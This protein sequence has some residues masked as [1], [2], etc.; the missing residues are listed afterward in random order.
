MIVA[1]ARNKDELELIRKLQMSSLMIVP[2]ILKKKAIGA[3][4]FV[5]AESGRH[6]TKNDLIMAE[7]IASRAA[8]AIENSKL[9]NDAKST[10]ELQKRLAAVVESSDDAII[11]KSVEGFITSWNKAAERLYGYTASE[12]IGKPVSMLMPLEKKDD[13]PMIMKQLQQGKKVEH[14]ETKRKTKDG[15]IIDVSITVSPILN[16]DKKI[17]G[18]SKVAHDIT[19]RKMAEERQKFLEEVGVSLGATIDYESTLKNVGR[20]IVPYLADYCRIVVVGE[21]KN[22]KEITVNHN[23]PKKLA[24]ITALQ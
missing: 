13:F 17:I 6:Y 22:I 3:I 21:N 10:D 9:Y 24:L 5:A 11:S 8:L 19:S 18:A 20:L 4:S 16:M 12:A 14:Y 2:L 1:G 23:L 15:R 7:E